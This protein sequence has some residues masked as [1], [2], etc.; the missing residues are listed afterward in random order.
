[1]KTD[2]LV[3]STCSVGETRANSWYRMTG[4]PE[5]FLKAGVHNILFSL[6]D[7]SDKHTF[8]FMLDFYGGILNGD[9]YATALRKAKLRMLKDPE[10]SSPTLWAPFVLYSGSEVAR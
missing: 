10:T 2:L 6:W 1:M 3:L 4:F 9:P 5:N 7:V 8:P